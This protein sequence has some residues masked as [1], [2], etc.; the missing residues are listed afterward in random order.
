MTVRVSGRTEFVEKASADA[1]HKKLGDKKLRKVA[2]RRRMSEL[3][4]QKGRIA[5]LLTA[6]SE[7]AASQVAM[8]K[9]PLRDYHE[10]GDKAQE[11]LG[12][13]R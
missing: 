10:G 11:S 1:S 5:E 6:P 7:L 4:F 8:R 3:E 2:P 12:G 9:M 13:S